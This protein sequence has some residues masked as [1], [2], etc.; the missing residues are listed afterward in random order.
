MVSSLTHTLIQLPLK[1]VNAEI[2]DTIQ[3]QLQSANANDWAA[4][5]ET[6]EQHRLTPLV[7]YNLEQHGLM[8]RLPALYE[9][10][11]RQSYQSTQKA[12]FTLL[13][14]LDAILKT[15]Q[16]HDVSPVVWKGAALADSFYPD[17]GTR[18]MGDLDFA[19]AAN[20][21][22]AATKAFQSLGFQPQ[23]VME[24]C[25][26][27]YFENAMGVLCD[28]HH[29][30]RLFEG[31]EGMGLTSNLSPQHLSVN[32][33]PVLEPNA[34]LVHLVV[35]MDG[36]FYETGP[37]LQWIFDV[38]FVLRKWRDEINLERLQA[39]M[40]DHP[41]FVLLLRIVRFLEVDFGEPVPACLAD[42]VKT[43]QPLQLVKI[44]RQRHLA[45]WQLFDF[46]GWV[47]LALCRLGLRFPE[48]LSYP[49][50]ADLLSLS[51]SLIMHQRW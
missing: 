23:D 49:A 45:L 12:N 36:H 18:Q 7:A 15:L 9:A 22:R 48:N 34:M 29:R 16:A 5:L 50:V 2:R 13:L 46:K 47:K 33:L 31:K 26:A 1:A 3:Q 20:E 4:S 8:E 17:P 39:L 30:V 19:I 25:D 11:F 6:L 24:T 44:L 51:Q 14:T 37:I 21:M 38:A 28:V 43:C 40:P 27:I 41:S 10:K 35:H 32:A 42:Q